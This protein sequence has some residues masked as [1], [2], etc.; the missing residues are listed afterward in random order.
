[1]ITTPEAFLKALEQLQK[2]DR[3]LLLLPDDLFDLYRDSLV[4]RTE[5]LGLN[6]KV[7]KKDHKEKYDHYD[8]FLQLQIPNDSTDSEKGSDEQR[9]ELLKLSGTPNSEMMEP[10]DKENPYYT[11]IERRFFQLKESTDQME[12]D[13]PFRKLF[14][15]QQVIRNFLQMVQ[16]KQ[17]ELDRLNEQIKEIDH[18][19]YLSMVYILVEAIEKAMT[20]IVLGET[21]KR[22]SK[23]L[24]ID[25]L[26]DNTIEQLVPLGFRRGNLSTMGMNV[27]QQIHKDFKTKFQKEYPNEP[28]THETLFS[29]C[30]AFDG[31]EVIFFNPWRLEKEKLPVLICIKRTIQL[32]SREQKN[33]KEEREKILHDAEIL[34]SE[35]SNLKSRLKRVESTLRNR[36]HA[37]LGRSEGQQL[38][39]KRKN[40]FQELQE[41]NS[42]L[43][44]LKSI[45]EFKDGLSFFSMDLIKTI[46]D[47]QTLREWFGDKVATNNNISE[48]FNKFN[49]SKKELS[50]HDLKTMVTLVRKKQQ[51]SFSIQG[52]N[53]HIQNAIRKAEQYADRNLSF[54]TMNYQQLLGIYTLNSLEKSILGCAI[55]KVND[56]TH[57]HQGPFFPVKYEFEPSNWDDQYLNE[58]RVYLANNDLPLSTEIL[59]HVFRI[60]PFD[61]TERLV[62]LPGCPV[63]SDFNDE[64]YN[65]I[66]INYLSNSLKKIEQCLKARNQSKNPH[67]PI[68][69][70]IPPHFVITETDWVKLSLLIGLSVSAEGMIQLK[71][72][73]FIIKSLE[74]SSTLIPI[75][76]E[77]MGIPKE[78][79]PP[80]VNVVEADSYINEMFETEDLET[81]E[82]QEAVDE[83][84]SEESE[85]EEVG[86]LLNLGEAVEEKIEKTEFSFSKQEKIHVDVPQ[87][88]HE[89]IYSTGSL[90]SFEDDFDKI[91][92]SESE[93]SSGPKKKAFDPW[94]FD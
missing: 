40:I 79:I 23:V 25:D 90:F 52:L 72:P 86:I 69:I 18:G 28:I 89:A 56:F 31:Y 77:V 92:D 55:A 60:G 44:R 5:I 37:E 94:A 47:H 57:L 33:L 61:Q 7:V 15:I 93:K 26:G 3:F 12:S 43:N 78:R 84:S 20:L 91:Q 54:S 50:V 87:Q 83:D 8:W 62:T 49:Q 67:I 58:V 34:S 51:I 1:M 65:L 38:K 70:L 13:Q 71:S 9:T 74:D 41:K 39:R 14:H 32:S 46:Q 4:N 76:C 73:T 17:V 48:M 35:V 19:Y 21:M 53:H 16:N 75:L 66:I 64:R 11:A 42:K 6:L 29:K 10:V 36:K 68:L 88:K 63:K 2:Q 27:F 30:D 45:I 81:D 80:F 22:F 59:K 24:I 85:Q 82:N